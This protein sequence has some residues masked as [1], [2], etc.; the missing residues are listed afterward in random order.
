MVICGFGALL[1]EDDHI[2]VARGYGYYVEAKC[3]NATLLPQSMILIYSKEGV[4][5]ALRLDKPLSLAG[6][7]TL[8]ARDLSITSAEAV[9][10]TYSQRLTGPFLPGEMLI[11]GG[12]INIKYLQGS[13]NY[14]VLNVSIAGSRVI[15]S[16]ISNVYDDFTAVVKTFKY[17]LLIV[18]LSTIYYFYI[19]YQ[20]RKLKPSRSGGS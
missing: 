17:I 18:I 7:L 9:L 19:L 12:T 15:L 1:L 14:H 8:L 5:H 16:S 13:G 10:N 2:V 3:A 11:K 4:S 6:N 20:S